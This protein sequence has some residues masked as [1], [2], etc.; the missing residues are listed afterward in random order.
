MRRRRAFALKFHERLNVHPLEIDD[1]WNIVNYN[2]AVKRS[3]QI[4]VRMI[5]AQLDTNQLELAELIEPV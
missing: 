4:P 2:Q 1:V 3:N 5:R